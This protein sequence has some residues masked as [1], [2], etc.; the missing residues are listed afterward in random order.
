MVPSSTKEQVRVR[1]APS[2]TGPFHWGTARTALFNW[3]F[4]RQ[5]GG[6]FI[7]R[8]DDTDEE[9]SARHFEDQIMA[10]LRWLGLFWDEGP[11]VGGPH[12]F[13][14]QSERR[15]IYAEYLKKLL[16]EG[17]AYYCYCTKEELE[18]ARQAMLVDGLAPKYTGHCRNLTAPPAGK[19]PQVI[20][21]RTPETT[22][23][24]KDLIRGKISF[25][26]ENFGDFAIAK[27]LERPLFHFTGVVDDHLFEISHIIRGEDH[28]SNTPKHILLAR[29]LGFREH[30][31]AHLP[32]ILDTNRQKLSKRKL[33][34]S[35]YAYAEERGYLAAA[36]VNFL[37]LL[38]WHPQGEEEVLSL[39]EL[40]QQFDL[41]RSQKGG[42]IFNEEKLDWLNAQHIKRL[43]PEDLMSR[44]RPYVSQRGWNPDD[45]FLLR[46]VRVE[47]DRLRT[48]EDFAVE[49]DFFFALP[50]Y[51]AELL[52]WK[53]ESKVGTVTILD[54]IINIYSELVEDFPSRQVVVESLEPLIET[55]GRGQVLWPLRAALS[56]RRTSPDPYEI[57]EVLGKKESL[58]RLHLAKKKLSV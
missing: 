12:K 5:H 18:A 24:F 38:G 41:N 21:F 44:I 31:Y 15:D 47:Q 20:R 27:D 14:R 35:I 4:A 3:L 29:A 56:G 32:L 57:F 48:L 6:V 26:T 25:E 8:I 39:E 42:A 54:E 55:K 17:K 53:G 30:H 50:D 43:D 37:A 19:S 49:A 7:L 22:V 45:D 9:R 28:I 34:T 58:E 1:I 51:E 10:G 2:P 23:D 46:V 33:D 52:L 40:V 16:E 11:E 13:Y 36:V